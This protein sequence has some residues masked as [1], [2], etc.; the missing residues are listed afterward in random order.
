MHIPWSRFAIALA[1]LLTAASHA[2]AAES[3]WEGQLEYQGDRLEVRL[4]LDEAGPSAT[5]DL[6]ELWYAGEPANTAR[7]GQGGWTVG[8]PFGVGDI[9]L[10]PENDALAG[11]RDGFRLSLVP[12]SPPPYT[13][14]DIAFGAHQPELT[15][16]LYVPDVDGALPVVVLVGGAAEAARSSWGYRS[17]A[18]WYARRGVAA[19]VYDRRPW[20]AHPA[21]VGIVDFDSHAEDL[22]AARGAIEQELG[23]RMGSLGVQAGSQGVWVSLIAQQRFALFDWLVFT[24]APAVTPAEQQLQSLARGMQDDGLAAD[25]VNEAIAYQWLYFSV[26]HRREGWSELQRAIEGLDGAPWADYVDQPRSPEDL[27]WWHRHLHVDPGPVL[28][29]LDRPLLVMNGDRDWVVPAERNLPLFARYARQAG[30]ERVTLLTLEGADHRLETPP[31]KDADGQWRF[32]RIHPEAR[33]AIEAF[34]A[35]F[36]FEP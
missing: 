17:K 27:E 29:E 21:G 13:T 12:S 23:Q 20:G 36:A 26:A 30:N 7:N 5:L 10:A 6:P 28:A 19:L 3:H 34:L 32:F 25:L 31:G 8:L 9:P 35:E 22:S 4:H 15:G 18:D 14:R 11:E 24:G 33:R 2:L 16:T 1:G